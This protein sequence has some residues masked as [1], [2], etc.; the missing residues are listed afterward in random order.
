MWLEVTLENDGCPSHWGEFSKTCPEI[1]LAQYEA[2][3]WD[4]PEGTRWED[5]CRKTPADYLGN[6]ITTLPNADQCV[7]D[8]ILGTGIGA[9]GMSAKFRVKDETCVKKSFT[10]Q[11]RINHCVATLPDVQHIWTPKLLQLQQQVDSGAPVVAHDAGA[12]A[13][14]PAAVN[15]ASL[16]EVIQQRHNGPCR[17]PNWPRGPNR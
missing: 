15:L 14:Q 10:E 13:L 12:A 17:P 9:T 6:G 8:S 16:S 7:K 4:V 1:G 2:R 11:E 5:A 3:L